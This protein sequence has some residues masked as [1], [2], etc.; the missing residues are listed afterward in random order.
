[1]PLSR[2]L[3]TL[4]SWNP[5]GNSRPVTGLLYH[6]LV[7]VHLFSCSHNCFHISLLLPL[8]SFSVFLQNLTFIIVWFWLLARCLPV[9]LRFTVPWV[10][11]PLPDGL[12]YGTRGHIYKLRKVDLHLS[13]CWLSEKPIIRIGL[14][15]PVNIFLQ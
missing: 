6:L 8:T 12:Y 11:K 1:M 2:N 7:T 4:T 10:S 5:L 13:R 9:S 15:L 14:A 3:G